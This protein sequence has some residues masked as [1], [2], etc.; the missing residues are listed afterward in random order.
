MSVSKTQGTQRKPG[1]DVPGG[2][3]W[4]YSFRGTSVCASVTDNSSDSELIQGIPLSLC[5]QVVELHPRND[6]L[7]P[8]L[9]ITTL[10]DLR[11]SYLPN[12]FAFDKKP[13]YFLN[14]KKPNFEI[15]AC[16]IHNLNKIQ[17]FIK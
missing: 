13:K 6:I 17:S 15:S 8:S 7:N 9:K 11:A 4:S 2:T 14:S 1:L 16:Q 10:L 12:K 5:G 3:F